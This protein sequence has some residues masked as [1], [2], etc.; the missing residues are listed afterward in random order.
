ML[1]C[2]VLSLNII[3][4]VSSIKFNPLTVVLNREICYSFPNQ[5]VNMFIFAEHFN[6]YLWRLT[7]ILS[8]PQVA[9]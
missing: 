6:T 4:Q 2:G 8:Q 1:I 3:E 9:S 5:A 7:H